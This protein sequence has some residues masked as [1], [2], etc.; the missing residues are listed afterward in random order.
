VRIGVHRADAIQRGLD[1]AGVGIHE[2][3][4]IGAL[5]REGEVLATRATLDD[6]TRPF[7]SREPRIVE[8]KGIALPIE[9]L[10]VDWR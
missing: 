9:V 8:L 6:A 5:A 2:A 4:R 7:A 10:T 1:Y 3:A